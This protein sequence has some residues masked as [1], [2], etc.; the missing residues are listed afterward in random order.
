MVT[1]T[2]LVTGGCGYIGSHVTRQLSERGVN[3]VVIDN[4]VAGF[5]DA[6]I[7]GETFY[8][9]D[10]GDSSALQTIFTKHKIDTI[11]HFAA[12]LVVPESVADPLKY[13]SNNTMNTLGL[14]RAAIQH[15]VKNFVFSSTAATY[16][17]PKRVPVFESDATG[18]ESPY[19]FSKLMS[20]QILKDAAAASGLRYVIFRYFNVAGADADARMGQRTPNAT[21][22]IKI[23]CEAAVGKRPSVTICG[24][25]YP[26]RDGTGIRDYIHVEDLADAHVLAVDYL[27]RGNAS[28]TLNCGYGKGYTVKEVVKAV[29]DVSGKDFKV[30]DGPRRAGDVA[31]VVA[32]ADKVRTVLDWKPRFND[33][34]TIVQHAYAWE[35]KL[36]GLK[37]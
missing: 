37:L 28:V 21:H 12:H 20:E 10:V 1:P 6:L 27:A 29:K 36:L 13:Y 18:P 3:V 22:L 2:V 33:L 9:A 4:L 30:S 31:E 5:R 26:T 17:Q 19:G 8:E 14:I 23:A 32:G 24:N 11:L 7:H 25:D 34:Q 15:D 16:G 35:R